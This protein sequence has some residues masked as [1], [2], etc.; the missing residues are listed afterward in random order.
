MHRVH[1]RAARLLYDS[2]HLIVR[3]H[4]V[5]HAEHSELHIEDVVESRLPTDEELRLIREVL[6]PKNLREKEVPSA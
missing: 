1:H 6:D 4:A 3:E 5:E 2:G